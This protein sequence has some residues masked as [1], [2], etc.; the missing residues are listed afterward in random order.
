MN[1]DYV[2]EPV[3]CSEDLSGLSFHELVEVRKCPDRLNHTHWDKLLRA[4]GGRLY[5]TD[6]KVRM[7]TAAAV[8]EKG[9]RA[10]KGVSL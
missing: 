9:T 4:R 2:T 5:L 10:G 8:R 3:R 6:P 1:Q 7:S